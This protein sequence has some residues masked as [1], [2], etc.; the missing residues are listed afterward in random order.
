[1]IGVSRG[2][3]APSHPLAHGDAEPDVGYGNS[4]AELLET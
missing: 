3:P 1:M 2:R 4:L